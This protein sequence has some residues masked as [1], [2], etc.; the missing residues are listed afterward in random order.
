MLRILVITYYFPPA[1]G[2][3]VQRVLSWCRHLPQHGIEVT[4][5]APEEPRWVDV[6]PTLVVPVSTT[7]IRTP[8]PSPAAVIPRE[9]LAKLTGV[10]RL[11]RRLALQPRRLAVPDIHR[12]WRRPAVRAILEQAR[13]AGGAPWDIV[14]SSSPPETTHL[15]ARDVARKLDIPWVADFRDSWLDLPHLRMDRLDVRLK[16]AVNARLAR[17]TL[18]HAAAIT[19]VSEPLAADLRARHSGLDVHVLEN[20]VEF[21]AVRRAQQRSDGFRDR[22]RFVVA[23]TGNFFGLQSP[24]AFLDA[25]ELASDRDRAFADDLLV[26]FV[27]GLKPADRARIDA[28][29]RLRGVTELA[30]FLRHDDVLATQHAADLLLLYVAPGRGSQGI[31]TGK[32]FEYVAARRPVLAQAPSDNVASALLER[33]GLT[34][35]PGARVDPHDVP[36]TA[37]ALLAA[38][39]AWRAADGANGGRTP[40]V[41]ITQD[42]LD[43]VSR[44]R[45]ARRL[46]DLLTHLRD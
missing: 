43:S 7:V 46:A 16:H 10:R 9:E 4:I 12:R 24:A 31:Y 27:G 15:I 8:D 23:Y 18:R 29:A 33:A 37:D 11:L 22:G 1:G 41:E 6:D 38:W 26:R 5:A 25:V 32:V 40:D 39:S 34:T 2:G 45:V 17:A 3:G 42:V 20:G 19:T 35:A 36:G 28:S 44:E 30:G 21:E 14:I 13:A